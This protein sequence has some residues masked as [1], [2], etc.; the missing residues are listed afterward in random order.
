[1]SLANCTCGSTLA[2][3]SEG[4]SLRT[5]AK[6]L[7]WAKRVSKERDLIMSQLL[8]YIRKRIDEQ[9]LSELDG[10]R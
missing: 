6:L 10:P 9:V 4:M 8:E 5:F 3:D 7:I 2:I 1:M